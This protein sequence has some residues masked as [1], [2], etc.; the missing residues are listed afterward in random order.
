MTRIGFATLA[1]LGFALAGAFPAV[2]SAGPSVR[3]GL[4]APV[5]MRLIAWP[6][7]L[8]TVAGFAFAPGFSPRAVRLAGMRTALRLPVCLFAAVVF[9]A[10]PGVLRR[11][12]PAAFDGDMRLAQALRDRHLWIAFPAPL[13][14]C[15]MFAAVARWPWSSRFDPRTSSTHGFPFDRQAK[16]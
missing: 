9:G 7:L 12:S 13:L 4:P 16:D 5:S 8:A 14:A 3:G 1:V 2:L 10:A 15:A 6:P 11:G